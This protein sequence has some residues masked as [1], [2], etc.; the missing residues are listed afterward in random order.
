LVQD[1]IYAIEDGHAYVRQTYVAGTI[2]VSKH[3]V[4]HNGTSWRNANI[5]DYPFRNVSKDFEELRVKVRYVG[6]SE[7][8]LVLIILGST[9]SHREW[10]GEF[11][12]PARSIAVDIWGDCARLPNRVYVDIASDGSTSEASEIDGGEIVEQAAA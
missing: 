4:H 2:G 3:V 7:N 10:V 11:V 9:G 12:I 1:G 5:G 8:K 6:R